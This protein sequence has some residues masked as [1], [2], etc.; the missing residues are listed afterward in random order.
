LTRKLKEYYP[1]QSADSIS[2]ADLHLLVD[3]F[4]DCTSLLVTSVYISISVPSTAN[5]LRHLTAATW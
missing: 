3:A 1:R 5:C 2:Y 4:T